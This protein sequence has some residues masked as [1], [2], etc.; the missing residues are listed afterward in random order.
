MLFFYYLAFLLCF[1]IIVLP[2]S[3]LIHELGH[4]LAGLLLTNKKVTLYIG[5]YGDSKNSFKVVIGRLVMFFNKKK[6]NSNIGLC[7][8]EQQTLSINKQIIIDLMGPVATLILSL[9][10]SY[11]VFFSD[12][13]DSIKIV[14]SIFN[15]FTYYS[16]LS[17]IIPSN[18]PIKL[19]DGSIIYNDGTQILEL[20]KF[21]NLP[22]E[23]N[24]GVNNYNNKEFGLCTLELEKVLEKGY[25]KAI[26]YQL[27][28][29]A[30]L[31]IK[32]NKNAS[33]INEL[34]SIKFKKK[35]N[36]N[37]YT[38][39]GLLKSYSG[40]YDE[41][42]KDYNKA[43]KI[44]TKNSIALNNRGYTYNLLKDYENAIKD[45][46]NAIS[47]EEDF[48][49]ALNNRGFAKIKL[50][51]KEDGLND[52]EKSMTLDG[53]NSYCYLNYGI[54]YYDNQEYQKASEYFI[55]AKELD[56]K[57]YELDGYLKKVK[58]QLGL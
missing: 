8:L 26:V 12:L 58:E 13:N 28:I 18:K 31:Q 42:I 5:S 35:F 34:Y 33:R 23:Y 30:Y 51:Q 9:L 25:K 3:T 47:I 19:N 55:K 10:L 11:F 48:A 6:F 44:D 29:S 53:K 32:D 1:I 38:N 50:G 21:K 37:D 54:Y 52:L 24:I 4:G 27:L 45:F 7:V 40:K 16:F 2:L 17:N 49:Y 14:L 39:S 22:K 46:D 56:N 57:T 15:V 20:I 41:A 36:S 43:V